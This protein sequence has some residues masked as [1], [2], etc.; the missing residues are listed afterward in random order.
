[1]A[2]CLKG[3]QS[4]LT[5]VGFWNK[6]SYSFCVSHLGCYSLTGWAPRSRSLLFP[7]TSPIKLR[8]PILF[9][10]TCIGQTMSNQSKPTKGHHDSQGLEHLACE[11]S[12]RKQVWFLPGDYP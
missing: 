5:F 3:L 4:P 11:E 1:M 2:F 10:D 7:S 6:A 9:G 12:T 8:Y